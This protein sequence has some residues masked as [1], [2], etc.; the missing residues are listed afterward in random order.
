MVYKILTV[1]IAIYCILVSTLSCFAFDSKEIDS[2]LHFTTTLTI[3]KKEFISSQKELKSIYKELK[4]E[5]EATKNSEILPYLKFFEVANE[6]ENNDVIL[7]NYLWIIH[8]FD[9]NQHRHNLLLAYS[10]YHLAYFFNKNESYEIAKQY[11]DAVFKNLKFVEDRQ[12]LKFAYNQSGIIE[13]DQGNFD[14]AKAFFEKAIA[15]DTESTFFNSTM[16][17]NIVAVDVGKKNYK[18][19]LIHLENALDLLAQSTNENEKNY[20]SFLIGNRGIVNLYLRRYDDAEL[21]FWHE[22]NYFTNQNRYL[23]NLNESYEGLCE[24]YT[25]NADFTGLKQVLKQLKT[26]CSKQIDFESQLT[27]KKTILKYCKPI[28]NQAEINVLYDEIYSL[29]EKVNQSFKAKRLQMQ[30]TYY[31]N[32]M[33]FVSDSFEFEKKIINSQLI[34]NK[35]FLFS[36]SIIAI[37]VIAVLSIYIWQR[38]IVITRN[39]IINSQKEEITAANSLVIENELKHKKERLSSISSILKIKQ[40]TESAFLQ[41][42]KELKRKKNLEKDEIFREL[43]SSI[44]SII[45][46]DKAYLNVSS[47]IDEE[48]SEII[49]K[50]RIRF[51]QLNDEE[52]ILCTYYRLGLNSKEIGSILHLSPNTIRAYKYKVKLKMNLSPSDNLDE[53]LETI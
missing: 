4:N 43:Q 24:I 22:I 32:K 20:I 48:N 8:H 14:H 49:D 11:L 17:S 27:D 40:E 28:L 5:F 53:I 45:N 13:L 9:K 34:Q 26:H 29:Q 19:A 3:N 12:L 21:D 38:N 51:P 18:L 44:I 46:L 15:C 37:L 2:K 25:R 16:Y 30:D 31:K 1:N 6:K 52:A 35:R 47:I 7:N 10:N 23:P 39:N 33:N 42:I 41:K 36:I 50:I